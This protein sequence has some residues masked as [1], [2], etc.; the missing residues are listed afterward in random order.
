[1]HQIEHPF[2]VEALGRYI[3]EYD[4]YYGDRLASIYLRGSVHRNE[5]CP[6][7]SDLDLYVFIHDAFTAE[8]KEYSDRHRNELDTE[9][10]GTGGLGYAR[11]TDEIHV[12]FQ[13]ILCHDATLVWG[14]DLV[15]NQEFSVP[16]Y[17]PDALQMTRYAAGIDPENRTDHTLPDDLPRRLRK[18][19]RMAVF[20]GAGLLLARNEFRSYRGVDVIPAVRQSHPEW[21]AFMENTE[22]LYIQ[23][24]DPAPEDVSN[25]LN[26]LVSW[27]EW[28]SKQREAND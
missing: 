12:G 25:Y 17:F 23:T 21:E 8:D 22:K 7:I 14:L 28:V 26:G 24:T 13:R 4:G 10:P 19:A 20:G 15:E 3:A 16:D 5:G 11:C 18:Y 6:G 2:F 27:M 9:F 1:M